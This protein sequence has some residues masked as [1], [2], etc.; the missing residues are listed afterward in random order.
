MRRFG[1][2][3]VATLHCEAESKHFVSGAALADCDPIARGTSTRSPPPATMWLQRELS[4]QSSALAPALD[5][6]PW[7]MMMARKTSTNLAGGS[8][9]VSCWIGSSASPRAA[10]RPAGQ[11]ARREVVY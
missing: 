11:Q 10:P 8:V 4:Q 9:K 5:S 3:A 1:W 6:G 7:A 2:E